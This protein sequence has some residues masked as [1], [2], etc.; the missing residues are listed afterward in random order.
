MAPS[1]G[2]DRMSAGLE[3]WAICSD[4]VVDGSARI[5]RVPPCCPQCNSLVLPSRAF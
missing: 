4:I 1:T 2:S 3:V 5:L